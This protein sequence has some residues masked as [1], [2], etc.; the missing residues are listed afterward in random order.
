MQKSYITSNG[1]IEFNA[2]ITRLGKILFNISIVSWLLCLSGI[3]SFVA[4]AAIFIIGFCLIVV[5]FGTIFIA[6]PNFGS[7][8]LTSASISTQISAFFL[9]NIFI[10]I[11]IAL[12]LPIFSMVCLVIDKQNK[13]TSRIIAL[14][15]LIAIEILML[16]GL[17]VGV[18][19][20]EL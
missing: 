4:T 11:P 3:L 10:F 8:F 18:I 20:W 14:S 19:K 2:F 15:I 5:S 1:K 7:V 13:H 17:I 9:E 6:I 12:I 16:I